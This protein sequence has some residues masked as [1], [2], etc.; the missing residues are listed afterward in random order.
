MRDH[1]YFVYILASKSRT[2]YVGVTNNLERR[3]YEHKQKLIKGF[4]AKY[5]IDRLVHYEHTEGIEGA[6]A[7][8]KQIKGWLREKKVALIEMYNPTW[9]DLTPSE[10]KQLT[11]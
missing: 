4:T 8:E 3:I 10:L 1:N 11:P 2:L 9:E 5:R 6:I 7:R